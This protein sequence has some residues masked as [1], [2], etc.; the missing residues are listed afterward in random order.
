[1]RPMSS[2][3]PPPGPADPDLA[4]SIAAA[5]AEAVA[6]EDAARRAAARH[7]ATTS[8]RSPLLLALLL[9]AVLGGAVG[10]STLRQAAAPAAAD[11][12]RGAGV[13]LRLAAQAVLDHIER[14][15][16]PPGSVQELLPAADVRLTRVPEGIVLIATDA[17]GREQQLLLPLVERRRP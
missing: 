2:P 13:M 6:R 16:E 1:M 3:N 4:A 11:L 8:R 5:H 17:S 9:T 15:G 12:D 7:A 10:A 14:T